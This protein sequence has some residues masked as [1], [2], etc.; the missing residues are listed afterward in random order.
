MIHSL[1]MMSKYIATKLFGCAMRIRTDS[2]WE[3]L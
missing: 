2:H 1:F 3:S